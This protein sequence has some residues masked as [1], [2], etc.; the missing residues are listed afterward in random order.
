[1]TG[2][3][4]RAI[5]DWAQAITADS[6][7]EQPTARAAVGLGRLASGRHPPSSLVLPDLSGARS[8]IPPLATE[9][10]SPESRFQFPAFQPPTPLGYLGYVHGMRF[11]GGGFV[12]S[13]YRR[14]SATISVRR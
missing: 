8:A 4:C 1:V 3:F 2:S 7:L 6:L 11:S 9:R 10:R 5:A 13:A 14:C 12:T